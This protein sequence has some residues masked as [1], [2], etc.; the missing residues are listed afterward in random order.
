M[1]KISAMAGRRGMCTV[2][3]LQ[4]VDGVMGSACVSIRNATFRDGITFVKV[5]STAAKS[6]NYTA[7]FSYVPAGWS[8]AVHAP[9]LAD[10]RQTLKNPEDPVISGMFQDHG[11]PSRT[12]P[13]R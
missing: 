7:K 9:N 2:F 3:Q 12:R 1:L 13:T 6:V 4:R 10:I 8:M 5:G 11:G